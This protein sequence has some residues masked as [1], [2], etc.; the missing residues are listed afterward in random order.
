MRFTRGGVALVAAEAA[1]GPPTGGVQTDRGQ[2]VS[3][4]LDCE[5][6]VEM[7]CKGDAL[8]ESDVGDVEKEK[9]V[10]EGY[11]CLSQIPRV[12]I[13]KRLNPMPAHISAMVAMG[14]HMPG[15]TPC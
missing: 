11:Y 13:L 7:C 10:A 1:G 12:T 3:F 2:A 8:L 15:S 6:W 14:D 4:V 9:Y 5:A